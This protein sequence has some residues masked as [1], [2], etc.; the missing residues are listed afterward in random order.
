MEGKRHWLGW[1]AIGL[2]ALAL[3]VALLGRGFGSQFA[4]G[5][6]GAYA[7]QPSAQQGAGQQMGGRQ[8]NVAP[9]GAPGT[10]VQPGAGPQGNVGHQGGMNGSGAEA[11]RGAGPQGGMNGPGAGAR[12]GQGRPGVAAFG[13]GRWLRFPLKVLGGVSQVAT[14]ALLGLLGLWLIRGRSVGGAPNS[15]RSEP[16]QAPPAPLSPTGEAYTEEPSDSE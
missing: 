9:Q 6:P 8:G 1:V 15:A 5:A 4:T 10:N 11:R 14:L 12:R 2:G 3:A 16:A 7:P 13:L